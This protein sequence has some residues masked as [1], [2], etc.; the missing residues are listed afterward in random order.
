MGLTNYSLKSSKEP[1]PPKN[2]SGESSHLHSLDKLVECIYNSVVFAQRKVE[3]EHLTR[4]MSTYFDD[5]GNAL[6]FRVNIPSNDGEIKTADIP[7]ITLA[8][9]SHLAISELEMELSVDLG[10]FDDEENIENKKLSARITGARNK[11]NLTKVK[12]KM[13]KADPPEGLAK[14]NDQLIKVLPNWHD[15]LYQS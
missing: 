4:L 9:N 3:T 13:N 10:Q 15:Y 14:I 12:I 6:T 8:S 1:D 5:D 11:E 7:L 2:D